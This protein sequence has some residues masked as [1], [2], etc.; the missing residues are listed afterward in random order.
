MQHDGT[1]NTCSGSSRIMAPSVGGQAENFLWSTCSAQYLQSF[2]K[3]T[4]ILV[5]KH[6]IQSCYVSYGSSGSA[7]CLE[8]VPTS[9]K[10][11]VDPNEL[12]GLTYTADDQCRAVYGPSA[13]FCPFSFGIQVSKLTVECY[14]ICM[15]VSSYQ[16]GSM[17]TTVVSTKW[18]ILYY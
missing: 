14:Q 10:F 5:N 11:D 13:V 12:V 6:A 9:R 7:T 1:G 3:Y 17:L 15:C 16:T 8:D 2:L 18:R 4:N